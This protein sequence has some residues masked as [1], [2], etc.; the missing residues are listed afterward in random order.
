MGFFTSSMAATPPAWRS[1]SITAAS[2]WVRPSIRMRDPV[3]A[4]S[5]GSS[6]RTTID[7]TTASSARPPRRRTAIPVAP[8]AAAASRTEAFEP[9][10][11]CVRRSGCTRRP[12]PTSGPSSF[13]GP[14]ARRLHERGQAG[15]EIRNPTSQ[16]VPN[17]SQLIHRFSGRTGNRPIFSLV[18]RTDRTPVEATERDDPRGAGNHFRAHGPRRLRTEADSDLLEQIED[19]G[20]DRGRGLYARTLGP[21]TGRCGRV[22]QGLRQHAAKRVLYADEQDIRHLVRPNRRRTK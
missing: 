16:V 2:I 9:A 18:L 19:R 17:R 5:L 14:R 10:P 6:S 15:L 22:E 8:A 21:P 20:I 12:G 1:P 4:L 7:S 13:A 3:P 11:Q